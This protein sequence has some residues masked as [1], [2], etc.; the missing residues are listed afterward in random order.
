MNSRKKFALLTTAAGAVL[1]L[2]SM[3]MTPGAASAIAST[4]TVAL[5]NNTADVASDCPDTIGDYW[6]FVTAP[7]N[8]SFA[9]VSIT[10]ALTGGGSTT[11]T[12][13]G[14]TIIKNGSQSDNVF[15]AVPNGYSLSDLVLAGSSADIAPASGSV[16]FV[17]SHLCDGSPAPTTTTEAPTTTTEAP[18]T[19][20]EAPTTT[21][22]APTTTTEA[23]TTTTEAPTTT[24]EAPTTT[25]DAGG[26]TTTEVPTTTV[27]PTTTLVDSEGPTTT[28][29]DSQGPTTTVSS[30]GGTLPTTGSSQTLLVILG[31]AMVLGGLV[32]LA[33][34]RRPDEA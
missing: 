30:Q 2:T 22:E 23:P 27:E 20:T 7:N 14:G 1:A 34:T 9:F 16:R 18:T 32:F 13:S 29:V 19:T 26:P 24:T 11:A 25:V 8:G 3:V 31:L 10:L 28:L 17:L 12:M 21:T 33:L 4:Q 5:H 15:V 6:H